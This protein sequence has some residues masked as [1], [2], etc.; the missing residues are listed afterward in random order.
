MADVIFLDTE[1]LFTPTGDLAMDVT[2]CCNTCCSFLGMAIY[3]R[4][5]ITS[6]VG[7]GQDCNCAGT[8]PTFP[9]DFDL[10]WDAVNSRWNGSV[11]IGACGTTLN[12]RI[13]LQ[14]VGSG[15]CNF[16]YS[17][18]ACSGTWSTPVQVDEPTEC[19]GSCTPFMFSKAVG[20]SNE[21]YRSCCPGGTW[22]DGQGPQFVIYGFCAP[23]DRTCE[24]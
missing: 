6:G 3:G 13:T 16:F 2:C 11:A 24:P 4:I 5:C 15:Q 19:V 17:D 1:L 20:G 9:V 23:D 14:D 21:R 10:T 22:P 8:G 18:D 7:G 12:I